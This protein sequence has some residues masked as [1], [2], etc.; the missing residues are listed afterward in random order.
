MEEPIAK[1]PKIHIDDTDDSAIETSVDNNKDY[2][3]AHVVNQDT[4]LPHD[5]SQSDLETDIESN[6][7]NISNTQINTNTN[8]RGNTNPESKVASSNRSTDVTPDNDM[9]TETST[10]QLRD[11][12]SDSDE[13]S[14][15]EVIEERN[16]DSNTKRKNRNNRIS[17]NKKSNSNDNDHDTSIEVEPIDLEREERVVE[18]IDDDED[19]KE[20]NKVRKSPDSYKP[21][22][23]YKCP[24]C[25][26]SPEVATVTLC[27]HVFCCHC[28]FQMV[29]SSNINNSRNITGNSSTTG[30]CALCR[31]KVN[32]KTIK[33]IK[34]KKA[35]ITK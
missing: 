15:V 4:T 25:F 11:L 17:S 3:V 33:L 12:L 2:I 24:I 35:T 19:E 30:L 26:D 13:L 20:L 29:N 10:I 28:L 22:K 8:I 5:N 18:I 34:L 21:I 9:S 31:A 7:K 16:I 27:G 1:K 14:D 32:L 6:N 23:D